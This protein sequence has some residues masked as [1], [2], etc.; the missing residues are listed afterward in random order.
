MITLTTKKVSAVQNTLQVNY[1]V[2]NIAPDV[3]KNIILIELV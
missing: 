2:Y 3:V 1:N